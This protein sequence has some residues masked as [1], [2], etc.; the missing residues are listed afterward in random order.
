MRY[1]YLPNLRR[2]LVNRPTPERN[3]VKTKVAQ[4]KMSV[5]DHTLPVSEGA[6]VYVPSTISIYRLRYAEDMRSMCQQ[7]MNK[8]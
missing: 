8:M 7:W 2:Y 5:F 4:A 6:R 3:A 1:Q